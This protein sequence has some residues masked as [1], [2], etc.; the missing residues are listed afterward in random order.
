MKHRSSG[1]GA[2]RL[3]GFATLLIAPAAFAGGSGEAPRDPALQRIVDEHEIVR[4]IAG[5]AIAVDGKDWDAVTSFFTEQIHV[6]FTSLAGG[7]PGMIASRDLAAGWSVAL[8]DGKPSYHM[9]GNHRVSIQGDSAEVLSKGYA[10]N[11]LPIA[12]PDDLWEV[13]GD[14]VHTLQRIDGRWM[15]SGMTFR[16]LYRRG[17]DEV[18]T[19]VPEV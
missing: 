19:Y 16:A 14:Y 9:Y 15:V 13:W 6:D 4:A 2:A 10:F 1:T 5:I 3:L 12:A 8:F 11:Y 7:E 18:R 17:N